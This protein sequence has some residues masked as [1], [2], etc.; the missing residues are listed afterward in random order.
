L[1]IPAELRAAVVRRAK[2]RCEYCLLH[3]DDAA[4][5]HEVDHILSKQHGGTTVEGNLAYACMVCNRYKGT[6]V[7]SIASSGDLVR[8]FSPRLSRW[9]DHF[10]LDGAVIEPLDSIGEA[11]ARLLRLNAAERVV[12]RSVL[13]RLGRYPRG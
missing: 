10:R 2:S 7:S 5:A 11:T 12:R 13:Q 6:N 9:E 1:K 4:F 8:L 3:Q